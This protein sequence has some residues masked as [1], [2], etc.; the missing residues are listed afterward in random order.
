MELEVTEVYEW[1]WDA[2]HLR[3]YTV[4]QL[5]PGYFQFFKKSNAGD[6]TPDFCATVNLSNYL[7]HDKGDYSFLCD[8]NNLKEFGTENLIRRYRY[9]VNEGSSRSSKTYSL[10]DCMDLY[11]RSNKNKRLTIWRDTKTDCKKTVLSDMLK[12]LKGTGRYKLNQSYN[13][14]DSSFVYSTNSSLEIHGT[15]DEETV[16]GLTQNVA[17]LNEPYKISKNTFDQ[18]DQRTSDFVVIDLNPKKS[19]WSDELKKNARTIVIKSTFKNNKFCPPE[20]RSKILSYQPVTKCELVE[21]KILHVEEARKYDIVGNPKDFKQNQL[22]E[23]TRCLEN[24]YNSSASEFNWSVYGLG[25]K[26][27]RPNRIFHWEEI[28]Y[29]EYLALDTTTYTGCDWG[30]VDPWGIVDVKYLDGCLYLHERNYDSEDAMRAKLHPTE[31]AQILKREQGLVSWKFNKLQ[32]PED[33]VIVCDTN[34]PIKIVALRNNGWEYAIAAVNKAILD[35]INLLTNLKVYY[36]STSINLKY[37]QEN[38]SHQVD[39]H[40]EVLEEPEDIDNHLIDPTRY[41]ALY[42]QHIGAINLV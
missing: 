34:R 37:E 32:I 19:H 1:N 38:Y 4:K 36:T 13:K 12:R 40:G 33:R 29:N 3:C 11:A 9:I 26:A 28:P 18:I 7:L 21:S 22:A 24:E 14:T 27:E 15:D 30:K 20:Q 6:L 35:G 25:E 31:L 16:H 17:W 23:L 41:V 39:R 5:S 2:M 8:I 42:L 10:I